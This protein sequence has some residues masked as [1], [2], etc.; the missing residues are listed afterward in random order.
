MTPTTAQGTTVPAWVDPALY[1]FRPRAFDSADGRMS[2]VDE[3]DGPPVVLVHGTPS[4]SFLYRHLITGLARTHRV[5]AP[6]H[7]GF[8]LSDNPEHAPYEPA[9]QARR[10]AALVAHL[11]LERPA[12][13]V[14]DFGGPIGLS[15]AIERPAGVAALVLF[16]TWMWSLAGDA[17]VQR[18]SRVA[19]G[20]VGRFL[21][22]R[23]NF[24]PRVLVKLVMGDRRKLTAAAHRHYVDAF[25]SPRERTA[26][27]VLARELVA[28]S[29]WYDALWARR[30]RLREIPTLLCWGD[31]DPTFDAAALARWQEALPHAEVRH[32]PSAGHFVMEEE[33]P[34]L[35]EP[36]REFLERAGA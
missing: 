16:N 23:L 28:S 36:V 10:L 6:D 8:G 29:A 12:L 24:S 13:V 14:H 22:R 20:P 34:A 1:P 18:A 21:Y 30:D 27:W 32:F 26:P 2:Y 15:Y 33:G 9:D 11:G 25:P 17:R 5:I 35:V 7:L 19:T 3:G 31:R 4:W